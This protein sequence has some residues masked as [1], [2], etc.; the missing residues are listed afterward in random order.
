MEQVKVAPPAEPREVILDAAAR[1]FMERGFKATSIDD[2]A[3]Q[4]GATK[5]MVYHYFDSKAELFFQIH[6]RGMDALFA[7]VEP[8]CRRLAPALERL[9]RMSLC[10]VHTLIETQHFQRAVAEGVQMH[11]RINTT[12]A[13][14]AQLTRLQN[15]RR[16]YEDVFLGV[17]EEGIAE[18]SMH[19]ERPRIVIK[20][21][22]GALNSVIN[23][24]HIR[25]E[26]HPGARQDIVEDVVHVALRGVVKGT[27]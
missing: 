2:I 17:L 18:G 14:R 9:T 20:P 23:W 21:M 22:L 12:A 13:Q 1:C 11:L 7:T 25:Y 15:R 6:Q 4:L 3:R 16:R 24:Y 8:E 10:H 26:D 27:A 5:G 19:A